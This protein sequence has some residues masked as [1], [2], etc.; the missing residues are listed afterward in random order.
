MQGRKE[1]EEH[2]ESGRTGVQVE[3]RVVGAFF[4][5]QSG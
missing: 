5:S 3:S 2:S 4:T 1:G